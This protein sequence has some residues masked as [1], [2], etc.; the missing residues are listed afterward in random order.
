VLHNSGLGV[1]D[2]R[3]FLCFLGPIDVLEETEEFQSFG[4][5]SCRSSKANKDQYPVYSA[6]KS[7]IPRMVCFLFRIFL[8]FAN[9]IPNGTL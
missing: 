5:Q 7:E 2:L 4:K 8:F 1:N 9:S 6:G 3:N